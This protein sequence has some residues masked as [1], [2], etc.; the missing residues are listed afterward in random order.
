M[1]V[2]LQRNEEN[3]LGV[4]FQFWTMI[5]FYTSNLVFI[6]NDNR[7]GGFSENQNQQWKLLH[8]EEITADLTLSSMKNDPK[9]LKSTVGGDILF[10]WTLFK[11]DFQLQHF[12]FLD[13]SWHKAEETG[14][15]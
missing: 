7:A 9:Y 11:G 13:N 10:S 8:L 3:S 5:F 1:K 2:E 6:Q 14:N 15:G 12:Y 4:S